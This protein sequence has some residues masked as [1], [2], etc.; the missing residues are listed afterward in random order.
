MPIPPT[1]EPVSRVLAGQRAFFQKGGTRDLDTR[2][3]ALERLESALADRQ[4]EMLDA[5][6]GDLGKPE[7]E[8]F[9]AEHVF[10]LQE[11]RLIRKSLKKW[12][13]PRRAGGSVYFFPS[14]NHV[15]FEPFGAALVISPWNYPIQLALSPLVSAIAAGNTVI[16]KPSEM[17]PASGAFLS[18]LVKDCLPPEWATVVTGGKETSEALLEEHFDFIFFTGS[19]EVGRSIAGKA[20]R[21][22]TPCVLE[23]GGKCPCVVNR[24]A[25]LAITARRILSGKLF[26]AGQTCFSPDFV[27]VHVELRDELVKE[28]TKLLQELPWEQ[29]M[30]RIVNERHFSRLQGLLRG[31]EIRKGEDDPAA[32]HF[33]P[34]IVA[35]DWDH[36]AMRE[37]IFG[38]I[39]PVMTFSTAD[40]LVGR[41]RE[42]PTPLALYAFSR[43]KAFTADLIARVPSGGVCINDTGK[44]AMNLKLPFGGAGASGHGC[45][46]GR[47]GVESFSRQRAVTRRYFLPDPFEALPPRGK[48]AKFLRRW[49]R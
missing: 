5:L 1:P 8:A 14:S 24:D 16:L 7:F 6:A 26:N 2:I 42:F 37:E 25:D 22:L 43:D 4:Q 29:E 48:T 11:I 13:K 19:T 39:L 10:V 31:D 44:H 9:L 28:L 15:R 30:A 47:F 17:A 45:Y 33:A 40:D 38:P 36:P 3:S 34:R 20:A 21:H 49:I 18:R 23:L 35:A 12:L 41:L 32:L 46:R 27:V